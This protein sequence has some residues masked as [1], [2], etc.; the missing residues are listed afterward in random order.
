M[1]A[2]L[3]DMDGVLV[4]S[5]T[6][7]MNGMF[8]WLK[9]KGFKGNIEDTYSIIGTTMETT[10]MML[11]KML[12]NKYSIDEI[13]KF[14]EEYFK[15]NPIKYNKIVI[16]GVVELMEFLKNEGIKMAIC[17]SSPYG[18][19]EYVI[20][21]CGFDKYLDYIISGESLKES[22]PN[23]EIYLKAVN[24]L[25]V[26]KED[27]YIIEDS[28]IG[29]QAGV[30]AKIKVIALKDKKFNQD[31]SNADYIFDSMIDIREFL[32]LQLEN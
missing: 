7:Y 32:S 8:E 15:R 29:I 4:D 11:S 16:D 14:N 1:K 22:K 13:I 9:E 31:Q 25:R 28:K 5:E 17:S 18:N 20:K 21:E 12:E 24:V 23:P 26:K 6:F 3:F 27:C 19:I 2:V 30:N 10:Y